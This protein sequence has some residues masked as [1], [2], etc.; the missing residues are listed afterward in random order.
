MGKKIKLILAS[1]SK[2]RID[3]L[4]KLRFDFSSISPDID[5]TPFEKETPKDLA[6]R[7]AKEKNL[8]VAKNNPDAL[9]IGSDQVAICNKLILNKPMT[10]EKAIEQ[11]LW[12]RG[13]NTEFFTA[14]AVGLRSEKKLNVTFVKSTVKYLGDELI[15]DDD[16]VNYIVKEQPF[17]C[18]GSAKFEGIGISLIQKISCED[19][20]A[21]LGL[22]VIKLCQILNEWGIA[23]MSLIK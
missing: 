21:L 16:I 23:P 19:P 10:K 17:F 7:L 8:S 13:K 1:S 15:S 9:V 12:Q 6:M 20:N 2:T 18:A 5:E 14:L 4:K 22:P 11:L 3:I